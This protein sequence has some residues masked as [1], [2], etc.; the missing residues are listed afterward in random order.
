M[1]YVVLMMFDVDEQLHF[2]STRRR[3]SRKKKLL[4]KKEAKTHWADAGTSQP[5]ARF[6]SL[7]WLMI[8]VTGG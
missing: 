5:E 1:A 3:S 2:S 8:G 6:T 4:K 7:R